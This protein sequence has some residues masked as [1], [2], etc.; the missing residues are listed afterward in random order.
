MSN[1]LK[2]DE[3][4]G[5]YEERVFIGGNYDFPSNLRVIKRHVENLGF[6]PILALDDFDV[7][8]ID[9]H[10]CDLRLLHN[11]KYAIFD[12]THSA[13]ELMEIERCNE[14]G[15]RVMVVYQLREKGLE[16]SQLSKMVL[17]AGFIDRKRGYLDINSDLVDT[18]KEFLLKEDEDDLFDL[19]SKVFGYKF[20]VMEVSFKI[21]KDRTSNQIIKYH[22]LEVVNERLIM[23]QLGP[24][25]FEIENP[26]GKI[27]KAVFT[28]DR[29]DI[30]KWEEDEKKKS[31]TYCEGIIVFKGGLKKKK[32]DESVNYGFEVDCEGDTC[33]TKE[34]FDEIYPNDE[35]PYEYYS[36]VIKS[37]IEI[38]KLEVSFFNGYKVDLQPMAFFGRHRQKDAV[39]G[40]SASFNKEENKATLTVKKPKLFFDYRIFWEPMPKEEYEKL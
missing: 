1:K 7:P 16:P 19:Y 20:E 29:K 26:G 11:C 25:F 24:Y 33:L 23:P 2:I 32:G 30:L 17:T 36:V 21:N 10:D 35:F 28:T 40:I 8:D 5:K 4:P 18:V 15:T 14:Y 38:L 34:E 37:P 6:R 39:T 3:M 13:G 27:R 22:N 31:D 12:I 9:I